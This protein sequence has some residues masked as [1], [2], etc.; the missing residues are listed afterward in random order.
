LY[1]Y[2]GLHDFTLQLAYDEA[3]NSGNAERL[4]TIVRSQNSSS[5]ALTPEEKVEN[6]SRT[7]RSQKYDY[8]YYTKEVYANTIR[9][10]V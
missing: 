3:S 6:V 7:K 5:P 2:G 10:I 9:K 1:V 4:T 8:Y